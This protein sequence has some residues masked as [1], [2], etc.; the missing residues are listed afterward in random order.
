M[1]RSPNETPAAAL[2]SSR[3]V[4]ADLVSRIALTV[5]PEGGVVAHSDG[6]V[7]AANED[8]LTMFGY[9]YEELSRLTL[10]ELLDGTWTPERLGAFEA[11][12]RRRDGSTFPAR[13]VA[14]A[15]PVGA[16]C[17]IV[18][19]FEDL[20][21]RKQAV[22]AQAQLAAIINA[23]DD[24]ILSKSTDLTITSWNRGAE[25]LYGYK[26]EEVIGRP[27]SVIIPPHRAGEERIILAKVLGGEKVDHYETER[28]TKD[29]N[30][31]PVSLTVSAMA[32]PDGEVIGLAAIA[33]DI[34]ERKQADE[35]RAQF[36]ANAAHELR[37]PIAALSGFAALLVER[38]DN[39]SRD[40]KT[41]LLEGMKRQ[42]E[43]AR[44]LIN[45][46][47][48][49]SQLERGSLSLT[50]EPTSVNECLERALETTG[51]ELGKNVEVQ[52]DREFTVT[53][54][55]SRL[56]QVLV[57]LVTNAFR[58]GG[59]NVLISGR[60][61][62]DTVI[63]SVCDD[64]AGVPDELV[65]TLFEPFSRGAQTFSG[66]SGLGLAIVERILNAFGGGIAYKP[67]EPTGACF[68]LRLRKAA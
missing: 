42:G 13:V 32:T 26:G 63:V 29:G 30:I 35:Y 17:I 9:R 45:N 52:L 16:D 65:P 68:E 8:A 53:A 27:I 28:M 44:V 4:P 54:D 40:Q 25:R 41:E 10:S 51:I 23:S 57:N 20:T 22:A 15:V 59:Q 61:E 21:A 11:P 2:T 47:L 36:I 24:A 6:R 62:A 49:L 66:G 1:E 34:T 64:G 48:D 19:A 33:R 50:L 58:Y 60:E 39:L 38:R 37:T 46:L 7:I 67:A 3:A 18:A 14:K 55:A 5:L 31:V 43:R 56:E 12:V